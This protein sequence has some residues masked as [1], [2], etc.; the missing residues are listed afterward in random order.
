MNSPK[1][2]I[3]RVE[4]CVIRGCANFGH[5]LFAASGFLCFLS[6]RGFLSVYNFRDAATG[7][8]GCARPLHRIFFI[9]LNFSIKGFYVSR[10]GS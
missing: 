4:V 7:M 5:F 9:R 8:V 6:A 3:V 2:G 10:E 1:H